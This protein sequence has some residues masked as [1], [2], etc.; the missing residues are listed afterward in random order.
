M[1]LLGSSALVQLQSQAGTMRSSS[2]YMIL[3]FTLSWDL[4]YTHREWNYEP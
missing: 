1:T 4:R 2:A 3:G